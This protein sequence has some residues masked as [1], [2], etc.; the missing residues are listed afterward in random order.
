MFI[1]LSL[2]WHSLLVPHCIVYSG[3]QFF[4]TLYNFFIANQ[5]K[6]IKNKKFQPPYALQT[7]QENLILLPKILIFDYKLPV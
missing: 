6:K 2:Y 1:E 7:G 4:P 3:L 5:G